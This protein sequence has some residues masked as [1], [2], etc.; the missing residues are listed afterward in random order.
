M[1]DLPAE[2]IL[3]SPPVTQ[4]WLLRVF[5]AALLFACTQVLIWLSPLDIQ[6]ENVLLQLPGYLALAAIMLDLMARYRI[7][8]VYEVMTIIGIY[9]VLN[10][11]LLNPETALVDFPR[12]FIT[13]SIGTQTISGMVAVGLFLALT[14]GHRV[15]RFLFVLLGY[16]FWVGFYWGTWIHYAPG[17]IEWVDAQIS[18]EDTLIAML[19]YFVIP[20]VLLLIIRR[21]R[22]D[23]MQPMDLRMHPA[24]MGIMIVILLVIFLVQVIRETI[25]DPLTI[26][27]PLLV[28][29]GCMTVLWFQ[30]TVK[31]PM[32]LDNHI[33]PRPLRPVWIFLTIG[34]FVW[35]A[36]FAYNLPLLNIVGASQLTLMQL[37]FTVV[38][39]AWFPLIAIVI[40]IRALDRQLSKLEL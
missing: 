9:A 27:V 34:V 36:V 33:P 23:S 7:R 6:I 38:G 16:S 37:G 31:G 19:V 4:V 22:M 12:T 14:A 39:F 2:D 26:L 15:R 29:F 17:E 32:V 35:A 30:R 20:A 18:I 25:T 11:L 40:G 8:N 24:T 21:W 13:R 3:T 5:L 28:V 1:S 10:G